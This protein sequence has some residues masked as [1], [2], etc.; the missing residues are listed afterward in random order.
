MFIEDVFKEI[1][2]LAEKTPCHRCGYI[3]CICTEG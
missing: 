2:D 3:D 1:M